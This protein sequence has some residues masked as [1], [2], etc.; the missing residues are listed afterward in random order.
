MELL[1]LESL[2][3][4]RLETI[5]EAAHRA[6]GFSET[7]EVLEPQ[8]RELA[9]EKLKEVKA[10]Q[11]D[12]DKLYREAK[13]PI[14]AILK[15]LK[16]RVGEPEKALLEAESNF[17]SKILAYDRKLSEQL[18]KQR[19]EQQA[20]LDV[21]AEFSGTTAPRV[22]IVEIKREDGIVYREIWKFEIVDAALIPLEYLQPNE[23]MIGSIVRGSKGAVSIPGVKV[24]SEKIVSAKSA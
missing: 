21:E 8:D 6:A 15:E 23:T 24:Y 3:L 19:R 20:E 13:A 4:S 17:K 14:D 16:A 2:E 9:A 10:G 18:E 12:L 22:G 5:S 1:K 7:F 11:K